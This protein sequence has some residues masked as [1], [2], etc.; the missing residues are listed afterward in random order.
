M[1]AVKN[2]AVI[3][4]LL[5]SAC[6]T[7]KSYFTPEVRSRVES[8]AVSVEKLQFYIGKQFFYIFISFDEVALPVVNGSL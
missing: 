7:S 4:G 3:L 6:S 5:F 2:G 8:H 1:N